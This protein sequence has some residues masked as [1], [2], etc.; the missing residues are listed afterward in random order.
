MVLPVFRPLTRVGVFG[1]RAADYDQEGLGAVNG[2][3]E[4]AGTVVRVGIGVGVAGADVLDLH[5]VPEVAGV[6]PAVFAG[7]DD[8]ALPGGELGCQDAVPDAEDDSVA[9]WVVGACLVEGL[10]D[11]GVGELI[12]VRKVS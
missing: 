12:K 6:V 7:G 10:A 8:V 9:A 2:D 3:V 4:T 11:S 1:C 5:V